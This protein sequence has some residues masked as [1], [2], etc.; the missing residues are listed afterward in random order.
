MLKT[1]WLSYDLGVRGDYAGL[2]RW[3]DDANAVEC[4]DSLAYVKMEIPSNEETPEFLKKELE[5]NVNFSKS[6]RIYV[7]WKNSDGMNK[8]RFIVGK[9]KASPWIGY[10]KSEPTEDDL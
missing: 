7:I 1:I 6:D 4:G 3:L 9:R 5:S 10:G 2:Y 8:G